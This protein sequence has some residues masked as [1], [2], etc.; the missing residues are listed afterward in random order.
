MTAEFKNQ[1]L[2][3]KTERRLSRIREKLEFYED[4]KD[5]EK[6]K[7]RNNQFSRD[8]IIRKGLKKLEENLLE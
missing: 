6:F 3:N 1:R 2:R 7:N 5:F 4:K 8:R